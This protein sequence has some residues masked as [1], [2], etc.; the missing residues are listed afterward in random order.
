[1]II[2]LI[3]GDKIQLPDG[4]YTTNLSQN[5]KLVY[6]YKLLRPG[7]APSLILEIPLNRILYISHSEK[8]F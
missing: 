1:M 5:E 7:E 6:I 2:N 3:I 4:F 8:I